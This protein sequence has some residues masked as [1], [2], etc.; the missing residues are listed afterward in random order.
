MSHHGLSHATVTWKLTINSFRKRITGYFQILNIDS[1]KIV[2]I[3]ICHYSY[4][5]QFEP[6]KRTEICVYS[7]AS[8]A[9]QNRV[10]ASCLD[11]IIKTYCQYHVVVDDRFY[12]K[13]KM[14]INNKYL[15][16]C[17]CILCI[18]CYRC[19]CKRWHVSLVQF[20]EMYENILYIRFKFRNVR[21]ENI[22]SRRHHTYAKRAWM[23][24]KGIS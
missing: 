14:K 16:S 24:I 23:F 8:V 1:N 22:W 6:F 7:E 3:N 2:L 20:C 11:H 5:V 15:W 9:F 18:Y 17:W 13:R 21:K 12:L 19:C 10:S 4:V